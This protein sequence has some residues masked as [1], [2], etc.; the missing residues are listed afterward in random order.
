MSP[1]EEDPSLKDMYDEL[2]TNRNYAMTEKIEGFLKT[3]K[4]YF[5]V[6]GAGHVIG[7]EGIVALLRKKA[8]RVSQR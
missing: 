2:I 3:D 5:V 6:V 8:Y 7:E 1:V 4:N